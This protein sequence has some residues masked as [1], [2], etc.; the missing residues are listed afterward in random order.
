MLVWAAG[1]ALYFAVEGSAGPARAAG[2]LAGVDFLAIALGFGIARIMSAMK[3]HEE[4]EEE[5]E[6]PSILSLFGDAIKEKPLI[7]LAVSALTGFAAV[8][9]PS[10]FKDLIG[11]VLRSRRS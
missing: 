11:D 7:T 10:L 4:E 5:E 3:H 9:N 2:V 6:P 8:K 1:F